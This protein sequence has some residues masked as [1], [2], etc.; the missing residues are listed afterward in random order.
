MDLGPSQWYG[1]NCSEYDLALFFLGTIPGEPCV[2]LRTLAMAPMYVR[3]ICLAHPL[4]QIGPSTSSHSH[5]FKPIR[6]VQTGRD[7]NAFISKK[8]FLLYKQKMFYKN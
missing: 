3:D 5:F 2:L 6:V 4:S 8:Y 7:L 1:R